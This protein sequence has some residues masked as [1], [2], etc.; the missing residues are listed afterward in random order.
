MTETLQLA[1]SP[2]SAELK[3]VELY[4]E[5]LK[6]PIAETQLLGSVAIRDSEQVSG[7]VHPPDMSPLEEDTYVRRF[8]AHDKAYDEWISGKIAYQEFATRAG[9]KTPRTYQYPLLRH[10]GQ[11]PNEPKPYVAD[12]DI[13]V[14]KE[15]GTFWHASDQ[16]MEPGDPLLPAGEV[17]D[18][19]HSA[20]KSNRSF[21]SSSSPSG[22]SHE[23]ES[24][25]SMGIARGEGY[26]PDIYGKHIYKV[27]SPNTEVVP[28]ANGPEIW[29]EGGGRIEQRMNPGFASNYK[30]ARGQ[31][32]Y[33]SDVFQD[34][35]PGMKTGMEFVPEKELNDLSPTEFH[36]KY[37][38]ADK[39]GRPVA[40]NNENYRPGPN[41]I[42]LPGF[43]QHGARPPAPTVRPNGAP[44]I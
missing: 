17:P 23:S 30:M 44:F 2:Q 4:A 43:E 5:Q 41:D 24:D 20:N 12:P 1:R 3:P 31:L 33:K 8:I 27:S 15:D 39:V 38:R 35:L 9:N 34:P 37:I 22:T 42:A 16:L 32:K 25:Y 10:D 29:A 28:T 7:Y 36:D 26:L 19:V 21:V 40:A 13:G 11:V 14:G 6:L 18:A